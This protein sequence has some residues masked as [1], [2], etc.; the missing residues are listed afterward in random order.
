MSDAFNHKAEPAKHYTQYIDHKI[1]EHKA[2]LHFV[3]NGKIVE[4]I[5]HDVSF[6]W[7]NA[8]KRELHRMLPYN[9][10]KLVVVSIYAVDQINGGRRKSS[11]V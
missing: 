9:K 3:M 4:T 10:G 6:S 2:N 1:Q 5:E 11:T 7:A 8:R